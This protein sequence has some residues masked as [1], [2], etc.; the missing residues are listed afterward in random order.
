MTHAE[1]ESSGE[2][3]LCEKIE[4]SP[5]DDIRG[6]IQTWGILSLGEF[7]QKAFDQT[8]KGMHLEGFPLKGKNAYLI[9]NPDRRDVQALTKDFDRKL[10]IFGKLDWE[11]GGIPCEK[12]VE[13]TE[14][15]ET[16][17][18]ECV[19]YVRKLTVSLVKATNGKKGKNCITKHVNNLIMDSHG[20]KI[21]PGH[22]DMK[23]FRLEF[24]RDENFA[25]QVKARFGAYC[26]R[27]KEAFIRGI[28]SSLAPAYTFRERAARRAVVY[29]TAEQYEK[30]QALA[31]RVRAKHP[32]FFG[33]IR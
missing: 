14:R 12:N 2:Y 3:V 5:L 8:L 23:K 27:G 30:R 32:E 13:K 16:E 26:H 31:E 19:K 6:F 21:F 25:E 10:Y 22:A 1:N 4:Q 24:L 9:A 18:C 20:K 33:N 17:Q 29:E 28:T 15:A 7:Q 11:M